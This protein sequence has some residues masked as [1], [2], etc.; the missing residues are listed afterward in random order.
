MKDWDLLAACRDA[1]DPDLWFP[2]SERETALA[3]AECSWCP[4]KAEC[5][6]CAL[7]HGLDHGIF[8]GLTPDERRALVRQAPARTAV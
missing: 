2:I 4:V 6:G 8:G 5:L 1:E 3:K 7:D